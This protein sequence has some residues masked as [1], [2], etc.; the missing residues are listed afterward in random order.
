[1][2]P[3][4]SSLAPYLMPACDDI[5]CTC[6]SLQLSTAETQAKRGASVPAVLA[7]GSTFFIRSV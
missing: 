2:F 7:V 6:A 4:V 5:R 3:L 1:M